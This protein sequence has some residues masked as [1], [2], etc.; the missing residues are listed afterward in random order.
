[1]VSKVAPKTTTTKTTPK[2]PATKKVQEK[3]KDGA[4]LISTKT[5]QKAI[6]LGNKPNNTMRIAT[7]TNYKKIITKRAAMLK[8]NPN[9]LNVSLVQLCNI[10][11]D[12][13]TVQRSD[14]VTESKYNQKLLANKAVQKQVNDIDKQIKTNVD[15][16]SEKTKA[17]TTLETTRKTIVSSLFA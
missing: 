16:I 6:F 9:T 1:M 8:E 10:K 11:K 14:Y 2:A 12:L 17:I 4:T 13:S 15:A 5:G 7:P 3:M